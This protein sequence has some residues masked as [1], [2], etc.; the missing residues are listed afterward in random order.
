[1]ICKFKELAV[2]I[3]QRDAEPQNLP[4]CRREGPD[5]RQD[6]G[7]NGSDQA[8]PPGRGPETRGQ[9]YWCWLSASCGPALAPEAPPAFSS[10]IVPG[11]SRSGKQAPLSLILLERKRRWRCGGL[12]PCVS[13]GG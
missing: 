12:K 6:V 13:D 3:S 11:K 9:E 8:G 1:M 2:D 5:W 10:V 7:R 4:A